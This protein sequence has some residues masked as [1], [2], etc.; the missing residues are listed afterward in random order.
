MKVLSYASRKQILLVRCVSNS[1]ENKNRILCSNTGPHNFS[2]IVT[3]NYGRENKLINLM[4]V[5]GKGK[6]YNLQTYA[7]MCD[8]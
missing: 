3:D 2:V 7:G 6:V 8:C 5:N 1:L 4:K